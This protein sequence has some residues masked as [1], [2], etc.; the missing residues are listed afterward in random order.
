MS[1]IERQAQDPLRVPAEAA[2]AGGIVGDQA[3]LETDEPT[4][5][6]DRERLEQLPEHERDRETTQG[7]GEDI[8]G[9]P[10]EEENDQWPGEYPATTQTR[11]I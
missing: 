3:D 1:G 11:S 5:P 4:D 8:M 9:N 2:A 7:A 10:G 6:A